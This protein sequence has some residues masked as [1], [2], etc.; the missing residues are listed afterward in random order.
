MKRFCG[1]DMGK[2]G[3]SWSLDDLISEIQCDVSNLLPLPLS[4]T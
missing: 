1:L 2:S 4:I 3:I